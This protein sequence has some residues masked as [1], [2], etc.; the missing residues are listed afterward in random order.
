[1]LGSV[2]EE[3]GNAKMKPGFSGGT[4]SAE[5][6][7]VKGT[8]LLDMAESVI[9]LNSMVGKEKLYHTRVYKVTPSF[10]IK[11]LTEQEFS[12]FATSQTSQSFVFDTHSITL[13]KPAHTL[14]HISQ[15][16]QA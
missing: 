11:A 8:G 4:R 3:S 10:G 15:Q 14:L 5:R 6:R 16:Q 9:A 13:T 2:F 12:P 1:M 7:R